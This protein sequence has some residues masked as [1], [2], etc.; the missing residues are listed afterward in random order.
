MALSQPRSVLIALS[1]AVALGVAGCATPSTSCPDLS[2]TYVDRS[3]GD[4]VHLSRALLGPSEPTSAV[5]V[6]LTWSSGRLT[7]APMGQRA[8]VLTAGKD[9]ACDGDDL[10]LTRVDEDTVGLP[11]VLLAT[12]RTRYILSRSSDGGLTA[13]V[14]VKAQTSAAGI[15]LPAPERSTQRLHWRRSPS[16]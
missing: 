4:G 3:E 7:V 2:G 12:K 1:A 15:T 9:F 16:P 11:E 6:R 13:D 8:V 14:R 10:A 5:R